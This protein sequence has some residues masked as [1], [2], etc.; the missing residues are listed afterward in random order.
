MSIRSMQVTIQSGASTSSPVS[1]KDFTD[2]GTVALVGIATPGTVDAVTLAVEFSI[3]GGSTWLTVVGS[4]G[5]AKSI[6]QTA[7]DYIVLSPH[8]YPLIPGMFRLKSSGN[9]ADDRTYTILGRDV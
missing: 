6:T 1:A 8:E 4:D 7:D 2:N 3:D 9:V 5:V